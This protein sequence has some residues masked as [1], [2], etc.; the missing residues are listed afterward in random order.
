MESVYSS[1]T[2]NEKVSEPNQIL[3]EWYIHTV[4]ILESHQLFNGIN[5]TAKKQLE[6]L[7]KQRENAKQSHPYLPSIHSI[8]GTKVRC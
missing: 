6:G 4:L 7:Y 8:P 5:K 2:Q 3:M 1:W